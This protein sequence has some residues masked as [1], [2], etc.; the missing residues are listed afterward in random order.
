MLYSF[1]VTRNDEIIYDFETNF[2]GDISNKLY[3]LTRYTLSIYDLDRLI[4]NKIM[5]DTVNGCEFIISLNR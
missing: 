1:K 4:K 3:G 2:I 5:Q